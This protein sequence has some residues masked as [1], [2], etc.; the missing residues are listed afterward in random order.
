[1][2]RTSAVQRSS[3]PVNWQLQSIPTEV[4]LASLRNAVAGLAERPDR[5]GSGRGRDRHPEPGA[6]AIHVSFVD[7]NG[8]G[9]RVLGIVISPY[10]KAG[11]IDSQTLSH[12]AHNKFI[13][14]DFLDGQRLDPATDGRPDPGRTCARTTRRSAT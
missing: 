1:V 2:A 11:V 9:L 14:D 12:D 4:E 13:E 5:L 7:Q 8:Y 10:A 3:E 6:A